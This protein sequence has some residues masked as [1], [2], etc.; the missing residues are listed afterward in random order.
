M[1]KPNKATILFY[2]GIFVALAHVYTVWK[3][4]ISK[5]NDKDNVGITTG[6]A[7]GRVY[8]HIVN[9]TIT[10][11]TT[12]VN[13]S[14]VGI[15]ERNSSSY[16]YSKNT[17][18][19]RR[20]SCFDD[21]TPCAYDEIGKYLGATSKLSIIH[22][23][24]DAIPNYRR[25]PASMG[26]NG[27]YILEQRR[28][29]PRDGSLTALVEY[30][31]SLL[32]LTS[33][34]LDQ[35]LVDYLTGRYHPDISD[36]EADKVKYLM[37]ARSSNLHCC[38]DTIHK[39]GNPT[40]EQSYL[41][42]TL[43]DENLQSIPGASCAVNVYQA[44]LP[45]CYARQMA[46]HSPFQ[47]Y[48]VIAARSTKENDKK[49]QLFMIASDVSTVILPLDIRRVPK[50]TNDA[51]D[52]NTK[53]DSSPVPMINA[54][55]IESNASV[56]S[57]NTTMSDLFYG[58]GLQVR[59]MTN[60]SPPNVTDCELMLRYIAMD[61]KK[62]YHVFDIVN[63]DNTVSTYME[64]R[65]H[66]IRGTRKINFYAEQ[67]HKYGDWEL[68]P[69]G[70]FS[71]IKKNS[72]RNPKDIQSNQYKGGEPSEQFQSPDKY[73]FSAKHG[74][75]TACCVDLPFG[76]NVTVKVGISHLVA[77][78][79]N[80]LSRFYAFDL[81][82]PKFL[83]VAASGLFCF[84]KMDRM[85]DANAESQIFP[86]PDNFSVLNISNTAYDCP[87]ITFATGITEYQNDRNYVVISYGVNDCY[88]RSIVVSKDRI[89]ELL[90][91]DGSDSWKKW[92]W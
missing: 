19:H 56:F 34:D 61:W 75:G 16:Y 70:T 42:L 18:R 41:S 67:F 72:W 92:I 44:L 43:L 28:K 62:N 40:K 82:P 27:T 38:G 51:T 9:G 60:F 90:N 77:P 87:H 26:N 17:P 69:N 8:S 88:S 59:L 65:P 54:I 45:N 81:T 58:Q 3:T 1:P 66:W 46:Q 48:Q 2:S 5:I 39:Y 21:K 37:V 84:E 14:V 31:P 91:I 22:R 50:P 6:V 78:N 11:D 33:G 7:R 89:K 53:I 74:R 63:G 10:N 35:K 52:W 76:D 71:N 85:R 83:L 64:T 36:E 73:N 55:H 15:L 30:N 20:P 25:I 49:D 47:D 13:N 86:I 12:A 29:G 24:S 23:P 80:Y 4:T 32:P 68:V 79:R 57:Q